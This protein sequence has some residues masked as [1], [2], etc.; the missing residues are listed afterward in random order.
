MNS[1]FALGTAQFGLN[2]GIANTT[3]K[4]NLLNASDIL[5]FAHEVGIDTIDTAIDYGDSE[6]TLGR[7][8]V[9]KW[10]VGSKLPA[11]PDDCKDVS[12][13]VERAINGSLSRLKLNQLDSLMLHRPQQLLGPIGRELSSALSRVKS[14]GLSK[15]IGISV[16]APDDLEQLLQVLPTDLVQ[17]PCNILDQRLITSGWSKR[18]KSSGIEICIRSI[19]LQG[20]LA[21]KKNKRPFQSQQWISMWRIWDDWLQAE[22]LTAIE[23]CVRFAANIPEV[24]KIVVGV[25]TR[26][27][28]EMILNVEQHPLK[29]LPSWPNF[30]E[31]ILNPALWNTQ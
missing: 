4:V 30:D 29:V 12:G 9:C 8:G 17:M 3:G 22:N 6:L 26:E 18:L 21:I 23:A 5:H 10:K 2:Y 7:A 31:N 20:I 15:K 1:K 11:V 13:W 14:G 16:Y 24:C 27:Q 19:F 25:E 28:L